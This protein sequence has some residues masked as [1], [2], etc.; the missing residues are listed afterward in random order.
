MGYL[1]TRNSIKDLKLMQNEVNAT[2]NL[3]GTLSL[4]L[5]DNLPHILF[6]D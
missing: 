6:V 2:L 5:V 1:W 3:G 4:V